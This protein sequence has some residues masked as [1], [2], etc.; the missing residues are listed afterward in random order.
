MNKHIPTIFANQQTYPAIMSYGQNNEHDWFH[1]LI[2]QQFID[3]KFAE[4]QPGD[5]VRCVMLNKNDDGTNKKVGEFMCRLVSNGT[6][7]EYEH[8]KT[9]FGDF[10]QNW[11]FTHVIRVKKL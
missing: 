2:L 4:L 7:Q 5:L 8:L 11:E 9:L 1:P 6:N 10:I 3:G